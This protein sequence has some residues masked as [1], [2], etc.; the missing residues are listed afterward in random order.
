MA[1]SAST[2]YPP[3]PTDV[4]TAQLSKISLQ[5]LLSADKAESAALFECCKSPGFFFLDLRD[6]PQG[7]ELL[8][9]VAKAFDASKALFDLDL[10]KKMINALKPGRAYG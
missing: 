1:R 7:E 4:P 8:E 6:S 3:F 9:D 10:D 2:M 5:K